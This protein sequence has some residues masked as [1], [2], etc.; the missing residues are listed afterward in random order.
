MPTPDIAEVVRDYVTNGVPSSG[1]HDPRKADWRAW[2]TWVQQMLAAL[3][4]D[5]GGITE[6]PELIYYFT[7]TGGTANAIVAT[8]NATPP[9]APGAALLT[10]QVTADNTGAMTLNGKPLRANGGQALEAGEV[11]AGDLLAFLDLGSEYRLITDP[12]SLRNKEAAKEWANNAEDVAVS[13]AAGGDGVTTFSAKHWAAKSEEDADRSDV[14]ADRSFAEANRSEAAAGVAAGI[15][16]DIASEKEVPIVGTVESLTLLALPVGMSAVRTNGF[17]TMGDLGAWPL[18]VEVTEDASPLEAWQRQTNGGTRRFELRADRPALPMLGIK[19][20]A[21]QDI[22]PLLQKAFD[23]GGVWL[24][25]AGRYLLETLSEWNTDDCVVVADPNAVLVVNATGKLRFNAERCGWVGGKVESVL[26]TSSGSGIFCDWSPTSKDCF[27]EDVLDVSGGYGVFFQPQ[28]SRPKVK[29][30][31][32]SPNGVV[33]VSPIQA[34]DAVDPEIIHN[35]MNEYDGFGIIAREDVV[36]GTIGFNTINPSVWKQSF[37]AT[38]GQTVFVHD[39]GD[40][41][42]KRFGLLVDGKKVNYSYDQT[43]STVTFTLTAGATS[44]ATVQVCGWA[45]LECINVNLRC[46]DTLVIGNRCENT[47]DGGIVVTDGSSSSGTEPDFLHGVKVI[48]NTV[49]G[50]AAAGIGIGGAYAANVCGNVVRDCG[51]NVA[52]PTT[53]QQISSI[54]MSAI[55]LPRHPGSVC[56]GNVVEVINGHTMYGVA[57]SLV[58]NTSYLDNKQARHSVGGNSIHGV[59]HSRYWAFADSSSLAR[60]LGVEVFDADWRDY[61]ENIIENIV[62][63]WD[64]SGS[65]PPNSTY[66]TG[67]SLGGGITRN[68]AQATRSPACIETEAGSSN[69]F[70]PTYKGRLAYSFVKLTFR[71]KAASGHSGSVSLFLR[72]SFDADSAPGYTINVSETE[73]KEYVMLMAVETIESFSIRIAGG[74]TN[75]TV[76]ITDMRL[77][78]APIGFVS[79]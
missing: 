16:N 2:G 56:T 23:R 7:V 64:G 13:L 24:L 58:G 28:G 60:Q 12:A 37:T 15:V 77:Q 3:A 73:E 62:V 27:V 79:A 55:Y 14:E 25:P 34:R 20:D 52:S 54:F 4:A 51:F 30:V 35:H 21:S 18:A 38:S 10:M 1:A 22:G 76:Y 43:G 44:G 41:R 32:F 47:G 46:R 71:A 57:F 9:A 74:A 69:D 75:G 65:R 68:T 59:T 17:D 31:R 61:P 49:I 39:F 29:N 78:H 63:P 11:K 53:K 66:W 40:P 36:G 42:V 67:A 48:A 33:C 70:I 45:S 6:L 50:S 19:R 26:T 8:P 72:H 5:A